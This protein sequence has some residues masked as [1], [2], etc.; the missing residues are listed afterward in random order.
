[1]RANAQRP[2]THL[3]RGLGGPFEPLWPLVVNDAEPTLFRL[4]NDRQRE[5]LVAAM[6][7]GVVRRLDRRRPA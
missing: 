5:A 7:A 4:H 1:M 6:A 3:L 2:R